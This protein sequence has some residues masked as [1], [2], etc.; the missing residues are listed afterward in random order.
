VGGYVNRV[1]LSADG[2]QLSSVDPT[3]WFVTATR[4][5]GQAAALAPATSPPDP[6]PAP[7]AANASSEM[8]RLIG[9]IN[10]AYRGSVYGE[11]PYDPQPFYT[12]ISRGV[13]VS[14]EENAMLVV[15]SANC[16][17]VTELGVG[18][19]IELCDM[20]DERGRTGWDDEATALISVRWIKQP[21]IKLGEGI[22]ADGDQYRHIAFRHR[23]SNSDEVFSNL[24]CKNASTCEQ[25]AADLGDLVELVR[26]SF[27][28]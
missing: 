28:H 4:A 2:Q 12:G 8:A 6:T 19:S 21:S 23:G 3:Q 13:A 1:S 17:I 24:G 15:R 22:E 16:P 9:R 27:G 14:L 20:E 26:A 11:A 7:A 25:M 5:P 18:T 10:D